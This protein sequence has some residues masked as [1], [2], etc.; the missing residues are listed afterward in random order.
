MLWLRVSAKLSCQLRVHKI[1]NFPIP[2]GRIFSLFLWLAGIFL[3]ELVDLTL[4]RI[5]LAVVH[6]GKFVVVV[7]S[8]ARILLTSSSESQDPDLVSESLTGLTNFFN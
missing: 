1:G 2:V 3:L 5:L 7:V 6:T 4:L 8:C